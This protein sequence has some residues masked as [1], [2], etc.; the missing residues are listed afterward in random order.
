MNNAR[1]L[2]TPWPADLNPAD[3]PFKRGTETV[4][5]R[6]GYF[7]DPSLFDSLTESDVAGWW[8]AG[9]VTVD[10]IRNAGNNAIRLHHETAAVRHQI[11]TDL[12]V[13]AQEPWAE[14]IW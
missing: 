1:I 11:R 10:D 2:G 8:N 7:D 14:H 13:V 6:Q 12:S 5:R 3:V 9:P 4:L